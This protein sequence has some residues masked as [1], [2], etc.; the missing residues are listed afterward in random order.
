MGSTRGMELIGVLTLILITMSTIGCGDAKGYTHPE[1]RPYVSRFLVDMA[2]YRDPLSVK[3]AKVQ[4]KVID[5]ELAT[6][7]NK[8]QAGVCLMYSN[9]PVSIRVDLKTW[10][11]MTDTAKEMLIYHELGHCILDREHRNDRTKLGYSNSIMD[12]EDKIPDWLYEARREHYLR[13]LFL[14]PEDGRN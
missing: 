3:V 14:D 11:K 1:L 9:I 13:E 6:L 10:S 12:E 5:I 8:T 2:R 4:V 7:T